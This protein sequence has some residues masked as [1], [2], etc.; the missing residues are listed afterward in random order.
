MNTS[1]DTKFRLLR[2]LE[3]EPQLNQRR[4]AERLGLSLG[5]VN[6]CVQALVSKGLVK[7]SNFKR[8][9]H[10]VAYAYLLTPAGLQ[11]KARLTVRFLQSKQ[12]QFERLRAEIA[13]LQGEVENIERRSD[14]THPQC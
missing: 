7:I 12:Q 1:E 13:E 6:Y 5:K 11:E 2:Q 3:L 8:S 10:K 4:L 14:E 9:D